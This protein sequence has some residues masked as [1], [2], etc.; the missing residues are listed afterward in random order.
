MKC[1]CR[2]PEVCPPQSP[3]QRRPRANEDVDRCAG[4]AGCIAG[5]AFGAARLAWRMI[6]VQS[7][8]MPQAVMAVVTIR[9]IPSPLTVDVGNMSGLDIE[10]IFE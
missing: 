10:Q 5:D 1:S 4:A 6:T 8:Q 7:G 3:V 2:Q 9:L